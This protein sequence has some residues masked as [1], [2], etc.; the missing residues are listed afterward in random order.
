M[1]D[2]MRG[3][4]ASALVLLVATVGVGCGSS[5]GPG[6][7]DRSGERPV[8]S[9]HRS[10]PLHTDIVATTFWVG[11]IFDPKAADGSQV[12]STYDSDWQAHYGGCDGVVVKGRC[13]TERRTSANGFF[14]TRMTPKENPFYL[15]VPYDDLNDKTG[16]RL[17]CSVVPWA[18]DPGYAGHCA[19]TSFS[20][21]KN[22]WVQLT[23]PDGRTCYGQIED[24]GPG[25]YHDARYVFGRSNAR[26]ANHRY[27]GAGADV[28]PALNGCLGFG[29]LNGDSDRI[30][31]RFVDE[32]DVP[33]GPWRRIVTTSGVV[34]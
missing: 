19:D 30:S 32:A 14:P 20:Y 24:A 11:E 21:M 7:P 9:G 5:S 31:W 34:E 29:E 23:G 22:R 2:R 8:A 33:D 10:Y 4:V 17:R 13:Q 18:S 25:Q 3:A 1:I 26:P 15:D 16:F 6:H 28:S 27:G 12:Y